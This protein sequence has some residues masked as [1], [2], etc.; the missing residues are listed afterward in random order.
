ML[1]MPTAPVVVTLDASQMWIDLLVA[2]GTVGAVVA[3]VWSAIRGRRDADRRATEDRAGTDRRATEDRAAFAARQLEE[4]DH[5]RRTADTRWRLD[6]LVRLYEEW[7]R[8][9]AVLAHDENAA[10]ARGTVRGLLRA[11]PGDLPVMRAWL[12]DRK[13]TKDA[14]E[15][16][17]RQY[18]PELVS[19]P[20]YTSTRVM[21]GVVRFELNR[22][23]DDVRDEVRTEQARRPIS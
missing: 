2:V 11:Y 7:E 1:S 21:H 3:A 18:G 19:R 17:E 14:V 13:T 20:G 4:R 22:A 8:W 23:L 12:I 5:D 16:A 15:M 9:L 6:H 10:A